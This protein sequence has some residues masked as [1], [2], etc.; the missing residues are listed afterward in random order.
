MATPVFCSLSCPH[1]G[2]SLASTPHR[3]GRPRLFARTDRHEFKDCGLVYSVGHTSM[4]MEAPK[5]HPTQTFNASH[6][7]D[8]RLGGKLVDHGGQRGRAK[9]P[10]QLHANDHCHDMSPTEKSQSRRSPIR[11][12]SG[13]FLNKKKVGIFG[14]HI[15]KACTLSSQVPLRNAPPSASCARRSCNTP[16]RLRR[17]SG[18]LAGQI[19]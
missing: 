2:S 5:N 4:A 19:M 14:N 11:C 7:P 10:P 6:Q 12:T 16:R 15:S 18:S 1:V 8:P 9:W 13:E 17:P 3:R